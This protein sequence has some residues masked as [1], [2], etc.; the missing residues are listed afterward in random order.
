MG[1]IKKA[2]DLV[3]TFRFLALLVTPFEKTKAFELGLID[4]II[5]EPLGGA[6]RDMDEMAAYLK[7]ALKADLKSLE[8]S[9]KEQLIEKRYEK[10]MA[11]GYC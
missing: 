7:Q 10:L 4:K 9:S 5:D 1:F 2:G 6:H 3:Y 11:F 8:S